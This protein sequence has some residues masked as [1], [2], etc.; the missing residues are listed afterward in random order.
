VPS[1]RLKGAARDLMAGMREARG[2][3][4]A[5]NRPTAVELDLRAH[6]F[7]VGTAQALRD[8]PGDVSVLVEPELEGE[9]AQV[10]SVWFFPDG[11]ST[12]ERVTLKLKGSGYRVEPDW[13]TGRVSLKPVEVEG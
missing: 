1:L 5:R 11:S 7:R 13:L 10:R 6:R 8:L 3:A 4:I 9:E 2:Q 12:G